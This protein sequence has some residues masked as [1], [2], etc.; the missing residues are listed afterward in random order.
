MTDTTDTAALREQAETAKACGGI[1]AISGEKALSLLDH[2][3]A[4]R[5]RANALQT[6]RDEFRRRLKLERSI[7]EDADKEIAKL[8]G[9]QVTV[10]YYANGVCYNTERAAIEAAGGIVKDGE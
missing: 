3:E 2:L 8:K 5:Q 9:E 6:E 7:L 10:A 4:E 1:F